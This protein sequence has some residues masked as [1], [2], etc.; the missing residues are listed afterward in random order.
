MVVVRRGDV[1]IWIER[2]VKSVVVTNQDAYDTPH[3]WSLFE[4][5]SGFTMQRFVEASGYSLSAHQGGCSNIQPLCLC[6]EICF[7]F[8]Y[9]ILMTATRQ[10]V[11]C[12]EKSVLCL[13]S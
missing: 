8:L 5:D 3:V 4:F 10:A 9:V 1:I 13:E 2:R 11:L 6:Y 7:S 12:L